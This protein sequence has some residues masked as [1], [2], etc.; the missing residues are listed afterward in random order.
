MLLENLHY[1]QINTKTDAFKKLWYIVELID[2]G[3]INV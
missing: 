3:T 1:N 2:S